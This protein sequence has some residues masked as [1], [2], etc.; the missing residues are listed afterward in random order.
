MTVNAQSISDAYK[1][2]MQVMDMIKENHKGD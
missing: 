1:K 2:Q